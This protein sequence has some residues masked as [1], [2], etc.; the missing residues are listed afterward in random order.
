MDHTPQFTDFFPSR[1]PRLILACQSPAVFAP[2]LSLRGHRT[3][4]FGSGRVAISRWSA[5]TDWTSDFIGTWIVT[6][7]FAIN[8]A[9]V[10]RVRVA[11]GGTCWRCGTTGIARST[12]IGWS[13]KTI[14]KSAKWPPSLS[15]RTSRERQH[16]RGAKDRKSIVDCLLHLVSPVFDFATL[17]GTQI[18]GKLYVTVKALQ[19]N[20]SLFRKILQNLQTLTLARSGNLKSGTTEIVAMFNPRRLDTLSTISPCT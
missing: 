7:Y 3:D 19:I 18:N 11:A 16:D 8:A 9:I 1:Q 15:A 6:Y 14:E 13:M 10:S 17:I 4:C 12:N 5:V 20:F 2:R